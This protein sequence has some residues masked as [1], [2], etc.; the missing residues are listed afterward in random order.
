MDK[1]ILVFGTSTTYGAWDLEGGWVARLRKFIDQKILDSN[2]KEYC[3]VYNLGISGDKSEDILKRFEGETQARKG[4][5]NEEIVILL[6][7]GINDC[8]YNENLGG[9][10]VSP[11]QFKENLTQLITLAKKYSKKIVIIGSMPVDSRVDPMPWA[12]GRSY[13]NEYVEQYN[14]IMEEVA[15]E[16]GVPFIE[17]YQRFVN[18]DY[19]S[20]LSDGV[21]MTTEGH[22]QFCEIVKKFLVE[23]SFIS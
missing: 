6:H 7:L 21:H 3:L 8:I 12:Q 2:Y 20:L 1:H 11:E 9:L 17:I 23:N 15:R 19:S 18:G 14:K 22:Q 4:R 10:E 5:H 16:G 13:R